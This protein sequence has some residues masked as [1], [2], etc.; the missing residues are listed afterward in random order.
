MALF[1]GD[2]V[3]VLKSAVPGLIGS[4]GIVTETQCPGG[5]VL[6]TVAVR[7]RTDQARFFEKELLLLPVLKLWAIEA[8]VPLR[9]FKRAVIAETNDRQAIAFCVSLA[10]SKIP[11]SAFNIME[12]G[13]AAAHMS[14]G[15]IC[16]LAGPP[17]AEESFRMGEAW[18]SSRVAARTRN[19]TADNEHHQSA[20]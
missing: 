6:Y 3:K 16:L 18:A 15:V 4:H 20:S 5:D 10:Q 11:P 17:T 7:G 19:G 12:I 14:P 9:G 1:I 2:R 8:L 13:T